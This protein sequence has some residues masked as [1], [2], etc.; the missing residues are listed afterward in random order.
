MLFSEYVLCT[1]I[2]PLPLSEEE[3]EEEVGRQLMGMDRPGVRQVPEDSGE[4]G[5]KEKTSCEIICGA[6]TTV[7]VEG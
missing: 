6:P 2:L 3:E 5:K 4:Q 7:A 1:R